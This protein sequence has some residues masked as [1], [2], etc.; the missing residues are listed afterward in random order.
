MN[1]LDLSVKS[2]LDLRHLDSFSHSPSM[3]SI[4]Q[5]RALL[6][7]AIVSG[8]PTEQEHRLRVSIE[9]LLS[10]VSLWPNTSGLTL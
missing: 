7:R 3:D 8:A 1:N 4:S 2:M 5:A 6:P 10:D 9:T